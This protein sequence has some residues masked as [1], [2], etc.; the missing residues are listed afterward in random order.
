[1]D[2]RRLLLVSQRYWPLTGE[3]EAL[4]GYLANQFSL[5]GCEVTIWSY[6][7][8]KQWPKKFRMGSVWVERLSSPRGIAWP[9]P[10]RSALSSWGKAI[11]RRL[12]STDHMKSFDGVIVIGQRQDERELL[13]FLEHA[14][15]PTVMRIESPN[16]F[17]AEV[18]GEGSPLALDA[19]IALAAPSEASCQRM[20]KTLVSWRVAAIRDGL[21]WG[22]V[23]LVPGNRR[24][25]RD[26][27]RLRLVNA[28]PLFQLS[29]N[30]P[31]V[32]ASVPESNENRQDDCCL[33]GAEQLVC[34][35]RDVLR[36]MPKAKLWLIGESAHYQSIFAMASE[37]GLA[38]SVLFV[39]GFDDVADLLV[40]A[41]A[42][43]VLGGK[44]IPSVSDLWAIGLGVPVICHQRSGVVQ[45]GGSLMDSVF[46][47]QQSLKQQIVSKIENN[48]SAS[49]ESILL[50]L[51]SWVKQEFCIEDMAKR[52]LALLDE[53]TVS[54]Q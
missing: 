8:L 35:W 37:M 9:A 30:Q 49:S 20:Q 26:A 18:N 52:Y 5:M 19:P 7:M 31:L 36:R 12:R 29:Q 32:V 38:H 54:S 44:Y 25:R 33:E 11:G 15:V 16:D 6:A 41:D 2:G 3:S 17:V 42:Y 53:L 48:L 46:S 1:M 51:A 23:K 40:A 4:T 50:D 28:H 14:G 10:F 22:G 27:A 21:P 39:G 34:A 45:Q 13:R 24:C 43:I 47:D